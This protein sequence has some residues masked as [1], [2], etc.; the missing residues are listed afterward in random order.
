MQEPSSLEGIP[1]R[2]QLEWLQGGAFED[3]GVGAAEQLY[4]NTIKTIEIK[5]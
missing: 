3:W 1:F 5:A 2:Q 4:L